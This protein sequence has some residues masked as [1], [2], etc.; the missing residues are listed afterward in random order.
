MELYLKNSSSDAER[1]MTS[2]VSKDETSDPDIRDAGKSFPLGIMNSESGR[3][4]EMIDKRD[5]PA[6][7]RTFRD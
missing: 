2:F 5:H 6:C 7:M 4:L 1:E 3:T